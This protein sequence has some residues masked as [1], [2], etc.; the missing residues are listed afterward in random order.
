MKIKEA[1]DG[2]GFAG[3][4]PTKEEAVVEKQQAEIES[5]RK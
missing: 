1:E 4:V 2:M 5:L 3:L